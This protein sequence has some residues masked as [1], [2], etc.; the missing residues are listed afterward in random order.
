ME[1][2]SAQLH[3]NVSFSLCPNVIPA[4]LFVESLESIALLGEKGV[5][6]DFTDTLVASF[7]VYPVQS[8]SSRF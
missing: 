6:Q 2:L 4:L 3:E 5:T 1:Y 7:M 8:S